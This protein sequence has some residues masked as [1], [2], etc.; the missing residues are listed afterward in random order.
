ML[1]LDPE[2]V[3]LDAL[4]DRELLP[5][6]E[7]EAPELGRV[8]VDEPRLPVLLRVVALSEPVGLLPLLRVVV[9]R[10]SVLGLLELPSLLPLDPPRLSPERGRAELPLV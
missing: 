3:G 4:E 9:V 1:L 7:D 6:P 10:V 2:R 5:F 8:V